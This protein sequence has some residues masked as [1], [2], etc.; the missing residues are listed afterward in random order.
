[1]RAG[2]GA[3]PAF[4]QKVFEINPL[5]AFSTGHG[6]RS[7]VS[8]VWEPGTRMPLR[9]SHMTK[10]DFSPSESIARQNKERAFHV[11]LVLLVFTFMKR[12]HCR[13]LVRHLLLGLCS[14][15]PLAAQ[16]GASLVNA[17]YSQPAPLVVAPGQ[18][19]TLFF[20]GVAPRADG[21]LRTETATTVPLPVTLS[22]LS[23]R[24]SQP[25]LAAPASVP[26]LS[27]LQNSECGSTGNNSPACL[28]TAMR[29]Q[30]PFELAATDLFLGPSGAAPVAELVIEEDGKASRSF[31]LQPFAQN[32]HVI[33]SCD[34]TWDI[35]SESKCSRTT[36]H[37]DGREVTAT[38]PAKLGETIL[39]YAY[40]FGQTTPPARTGQLSPQ[41]ASVP[42]VLNQKPRVVVTIEDEIL[43]A[44]AWLPRT[45]DNPPVNLTPLTIPFAG[46]TP[47]QVGLYQVNIPIPT[48][49]RIPVLC[50]AIP[51][52]TPVTSNA[53]IKVSTIQ[54]T[55]FVPICIAP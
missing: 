33:T 4:K 47:N 10:A 52:S 22:G 28:L 17:T 3:W 1:V 8:I 32:G 18:I 26:I 13:R 43:D 37:A 23:L 25:G 49:L 2:F 19:V 20:R 31:L 54:G 11:V 40:G 36:Y 24:I 29:I 38:E 42:T 51:N 34:L 44:P 48:S 35:K 14:L 21:S 46:L 27:V 53:L 15:L 16:T 6:T 39:V 55:D 9:K 50:D 45:F 41:G 5:T 7:P 12:I 30:I